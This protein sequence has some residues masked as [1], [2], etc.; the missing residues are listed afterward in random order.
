VEDPIE[1][2]IPGVTQTQVNRE[3]GYTFAKALRSLLRQNPNILLVGE[4][5]DKETAL[6]AWQASLTGHLVLSTIHANDALEV[7]DRLESL[8]IPPQKILPSLNAIISQRLVRKKIPS[9]G[10]KIQEALQN[11]SGW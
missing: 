6:L 5:R 3:K 2:R 7:F 10:K 4:I 1:Y 11:L 9:R 8:G